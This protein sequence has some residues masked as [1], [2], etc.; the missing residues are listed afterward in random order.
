MTSCGWLLSVLRAPVGTG[1]YPNEDDP[2]YLI[3]TSCETLSKNGLNHSLMDLLEIVHHSSL[4]EVLDHLGLPTFGARVRAR[5]GLKALYKTY[6]SHLESQG[7]L[8]TQRDQHCVTSE[9]KRLENANENTIANVN[10]N[11]N[12]EVK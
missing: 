3:S 5:A 1:I 9:S 4:E 11:V 7:L 12:A 2:E 10:V 8:S 6:T